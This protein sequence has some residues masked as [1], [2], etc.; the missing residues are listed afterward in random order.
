[1]IGVDRI[2]GAASGTDRESRGRRSDRPGARRARRVGSATLLW[3]LLA[4]GALGGCTSSD[5]DCDGGISGTGCEGFDVATGPG[6]QGSNGPD[7]VVGGGGSGGTGGPAR[8]FVNATPALDGIDARL[9]VVNLSSGAVDLVLGE[10]TVR[11][12]AIPAGEVGALV[13]TDASTRA[14]ALLEDGSG[15]PIG[16]FATTLSPGTLTTFVAFDAADGTPA[17]A[18]LVTRAG[19]D[20]PGI[21]LVRVVY[22]IDPA[23]A[24]ARLAT[25]GLEPGGDDPGGAAVGFEPDPD[26]GASPI[27]SAYAPVPAG[28]YAL[29]VDGRADRVDVSFEGGVAY[30]L[31]LSDTG[32]P[33]GEGR[34]L[35]LVD[36]PPR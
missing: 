1:M 36:G 3:A 10:S 12:D 28:D 29:G 35:Q 8:D 16:R 4:A 27:A 20:D 19:T 21:A 32:G 14:V 24:P 23:D 31:M 18:A 9:R 22:A 7:A 6:E 33:D 25:L 13:S 34:F 26:P 17:A 30:T 2:A 15:E 5:G 11:D